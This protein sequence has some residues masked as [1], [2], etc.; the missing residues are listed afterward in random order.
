MTPQNR[1]AHQRFDLH[2]SAEITTAAGVVT[3]VTKDLS[4]GGCCL[5]SAYQLTE[6]ATIQL[7]LFLVVDGIEDTDTPPLIIPAHIQWTAE[8]D[9]AA[10]DSRHLA[11]MRFEGSPEQSAWLDNFLAR[12]PE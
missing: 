2:L 6:G 3:A 12:L 7:A 1:R 11:G 5:E 10:L 8:N 4:V 9:E